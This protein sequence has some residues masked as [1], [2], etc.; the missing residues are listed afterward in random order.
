MKS[1]GRNLGLIS[2]IFAIILGLLVGFFI[3]LYSNPSQAIGGFKT[4]L[5]GALTDGSKG[6]GMVLYYATPI[7]CTGLSIG[8][9]F[10]TGLFN[11]GATGQF[12]VGAFAAVVVGI[13]ATELGNAHWM[14][15]L[16]ASVIAGA[17]WALI[18]GLLKAYANINEVIAGIMTNYIGMYLVNW[19]VKDSNAL[20]N[21]LENRS[22]PVAP[23]AIIPKAG[24][25]QIFKGSYVNAGIIIA[26]I[27]AIIIYI[28][29]DK[30]TFGYELK[31]VGFNRDASKYAGINEKKSIIWSM[32]I[33]GALAGLGG[34][35][36]YLAGSGKYIEVVDELAAEGFD[37]ISVALLGLSHPIGILLAAI[38]IAYIKQ[39][40]FYLQLF[41]YSKEII[42]IIIAVI[43]YFSAFSMIVRNIIT[44]RE[45]KR[46]VD[47][48]V[49]SAQIPTPINE[50]S[51]YGS[52]TEEEIR[53]ASK[54]DIQ[55]EDDLR[56]DSEHD[57]MSFKD[58]G[59]VKEGSEE[60]TL[61]ED[62]QEGTLKEDSEEGILKED[63]KE[64]TL[65]EVNKGN[66]NVDNK[67]NNNVDSKEINNVDSNKNNNVDSNEDE[68]VDKMKGGNK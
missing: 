31:A 23:T 63:S 51:V 24:L 48:S 9:A 32:V 13:T 4:I 40:G 7:I 52:K 68:K 35:L 22:K 55:R 60:R 27:A 57:D 25:N 44:N 10:K 2:S 58:E 19:S 26:I 43:I 6:I 54:K 59:T 8:F 66:N 56:N 1:R 37:G 34:G 67:G 21:M 45:R 47:R 41:E 5:T 12:T 65:N 33:S 3:L 28:I 14:V 16:F 50:P 49:G 18:P 11:I 46:R 62:I 29:L 30:T 61:S 64:S 20:F 39:G 15:A 38:F 53:E 36:L 17:L 42:D